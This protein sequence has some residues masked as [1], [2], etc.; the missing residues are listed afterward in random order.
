MIHEVTPQVGSY[1]RRKRIGRGVGS[2]HGKTSG[3]GVKGAGSR[4]GWSGSIRPSREGGQTALFRRIPKRG[5]SN[6]KFRVEYEVVNIKTLENRFADGA[7]INPQSLV[8]AG[9]ISS[10]SK[11]VKVLGE[12]DLSKKLHVTAAAFSAI[13]S[14]KITKAGGTAT[15]AARKP[16]AEAAAPSGSKAAAKPAA[17]STPAKKK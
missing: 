7:T 3:R 4:S 13:A 2:G 5:F 6:F 12:G 11:P 15:V 9:L 16:A 17:K 8:K 10:A 14:E 1:K